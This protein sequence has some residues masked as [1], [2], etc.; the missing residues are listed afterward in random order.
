MLICKYCYSTIV[1]CMVFFEIVWACNT[2][3]PYA[4]R[5]VSG[6]DESTAGLHQ[7]YPLLVTSLGG[8]GTH[9]ITC[10]MNALNIEVGHETIKRDGA[11][12]CV[13]W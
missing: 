11:V 3:V 10:M 5:A 4:R 8:A 6:C 12:V 1:L 13:D 9:H 2:M 7:V